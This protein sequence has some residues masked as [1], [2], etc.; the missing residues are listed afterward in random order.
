MSLTYGFY[1]SLNHDRTYSTLQFSSIFDGIISDGIYATYLD[2]LQVRASD[3]TN[4]NINVMPGR[5]WFNH[6][7]TLND[8]VLTLTVEDPDVALPRIDTVILE[9]N[10]DISGRENS[11]Y[12]L[13]GTPASNPIP[14][15]LS[16]GDNNLY[17]YPLA[18]IAVANRDN[19]ITNG[20]IRD[21]DI[22]N[23][24]GTEDTPFVTGLIDHITI[25]NLTSQ[26]MTEFEELFIELEEMI[27]QAASQS[28]IDNSVTTPKIANGAVT[29]D[30]L[31]PA[32]QGTIASKADSS[33]LC[34]VI[35]GAASP[36]TSIQAGSYIILKNSTIS[37]ITD[38][39]Y[40]AA[41][42]IPANTVIDS[43][44]LTEFSGGGLNH[45]KSSY[46]KWMFPKGTPINV[47]LSTNGT[48][49]TAPSDGNLEIR[50]YNGYLLIDGPTSIMTADSNYSVATSPDNATVAIS[51]M[52][53]G[54]TATV[55]RTATISR[56]SF[57][58]C[59]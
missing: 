32:L 1:D 9:V 33:Y 59:G 15:P 14:A 27:S 56:A 43:T 55:W 31:S 19:V 24:R 46:E 49:Y 58:P 3:P 39:L 48:Q 54:A 29:G 18:Y 45:L 20:G 25:E 40:K 7:W 5:A 34:Y 51:H 21:I 11:I 37:G 42:A 47:S 4:M 35:T 13:K 36:P 12:I 28:L 2:A 22:T 10:S 44:Y 52:K 6:T 53:K 57:T 23:K 16:H 26:W 30:K 50:F 8:A 41:K 17:Q 38:G